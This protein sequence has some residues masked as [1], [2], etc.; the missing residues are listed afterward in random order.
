MKEFDSSQIHSQR[1]IFGE[2]AFPEI[3]VGI[4]GRDFSY[5]V[6]PQKVFT[7][8][9]DFAMRM[10]HTDPETGEVE[11][12]F[13]VSDSVPEEMRDFWVLH[14]YVEFIEIGID[15]K[16]RCVEA[17]IQV[18]QTIPDDLAPQY[19]LRRIIFFQNL[20]NFFQDEIESGVT[21]YTK[22][23]IKE[24]QNTLFILKSI[25]ELSLE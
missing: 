16:G 23:D 5:F 20:I 3:R 6:I 1:K 8:L 19:V 25:S 17:E 9:P 2:A 22:E 18:V 15:Q 14:E 21:E 24:A 7:A 12:I 13:G 10:T 11:G 4:G